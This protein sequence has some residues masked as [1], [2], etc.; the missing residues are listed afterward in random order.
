LTGIDEEGTHVRLKEHL[1]VLVDPKIIEHRGRTVKNTG[2]GMIAEFNSVVDALR[3]ALDIQRGMARR[4]ADTPQSERIEFRV[5]V[6]VGDVIIDD[7]DIFGDGV[8]I[9]VRLES[10]AEP[11]GI[12]VSDRVQ[13]YAEGQFDL[14]F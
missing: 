13:E 5:G 7:N 9:A 14:T 6:N 12:C 8:N 11:G 3:C 1:R 2:D 10:L 4:N